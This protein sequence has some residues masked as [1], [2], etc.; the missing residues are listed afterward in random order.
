LEEI[1]RVKLFSKKENL[2]KAN[3]INILDEYMDKNYNILQRNDE[4]RSDERN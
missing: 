1:N 3:R 2:T 4:R